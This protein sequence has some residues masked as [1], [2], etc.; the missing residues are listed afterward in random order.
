MLS[1][2]P[3]EKFRLPQWYDEAVYLLDK[4]VP[5]RY[6]ISHTNRKL[7]QTVNYIIVGIAHKYGGAWCV[8]NFAKKLLCSTLNIITDDSDFFYE[9]V[10]QDDK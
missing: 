6:A 3:D 2:P 10:S 7:V 9:V 4:K 5:P 1:Y 8:Y